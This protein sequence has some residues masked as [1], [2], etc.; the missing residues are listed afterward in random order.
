MYYYKV[1]RPSKNIFQRRKYK[2]LCLASRS[3][4]ARGR[5]W[6]W[7]ISY[8]HHTQ[9][10]LEENKEEE[11][12]EI[13]ESDIFKAQE[14]QNGKKPNQFLSFSFYATDVSLAVSNLIVVGIVKMK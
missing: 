7:L 10:G 5:G 3:Y 12:M 2:P 11:M 13:K 6:E 4:E 9:A 8:P 14:A 1:C